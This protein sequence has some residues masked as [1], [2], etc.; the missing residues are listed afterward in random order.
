MSIEAALTAWATTEDIRDLAEQLLVLGHRKAAEEL[1]AG[2]L[3]GDESALAAKDKVKRL[4]LEG[5]KGPGMALPA[6]LQFLA[7][8]TA[9][10]NPQPESEPRQPALQPAGDTYFVAT[11]VTPCATR[12]AAMALMNDLAEQ[13]VVFRLVRGVE[14]KVRTKVVEIEG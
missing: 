6:V 9:A 14:V 12:E 4:I 2:D 11:S 7:T 3:P 1:M 13:G 5:D 10:R 8:R